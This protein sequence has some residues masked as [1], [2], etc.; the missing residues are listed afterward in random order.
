MSVKRGC[1]YCTDLAVNLTDAT[2]PSQ[3]SAEVM[4][5][6]QVARCYALL[7]K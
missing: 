6:L 1:E 4:K 7:V 3:Y 5:E 2:E